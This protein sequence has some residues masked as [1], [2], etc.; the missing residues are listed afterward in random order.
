M[1]RRPGKPG[2]GAC[3]T[4]EEIES[5]RFDRAEHP[6]CPFGKTAAQSR[7]Q[8]QGRAHRRQRREDAL[9]SESL[10]GNIRFIA[11]SHP[12]PAVPSDAI[13]ASTSRFKAIAVP[14]SNGCARTCE[15]LIHRKPS[16]SRS[17]SRIAGDAADIGT[18]AAQW[19]CRNPGRVSSEVL[20]APPGRG[21]CSSTVT[22]SPWP[23]RW[24]AATSPLCPAPITRTRATGSSYPP[25]SMRTHARSS[26][27]VLRS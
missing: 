1:L 15:G 17:S 3:V 19:S 27:L 9:T 8:P 11:A 16:D 10:S 2:C 26:S 12:A 14:S 22:S 20:V 24:I 6:A 4:V 13:V 25:G 7:G 18:K 5:E 21:A 23:A